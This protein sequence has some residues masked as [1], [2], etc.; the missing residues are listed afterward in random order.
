MGYSH[1]VWCWPLQRSRLLDSIVWLPL[2]LIDY[3]CRPAAAAPP[4]YNELGWSR[5]MFLH[6]KWSMHKVWV[7]GVQ[8]WIVTDQ[9]SLLIQG[10]KQLCAEHPECVL[11]RA[12]GLLQPL[13]LALS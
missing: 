7:G 1:W 9:V 12:A 13:Y 5:R 8:S 10:P 2:L 11:V 3:L 4:P 6:M